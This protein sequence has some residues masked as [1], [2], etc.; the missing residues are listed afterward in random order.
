MTKSERPLNA[1]TVLIVGAGPTGLTLACELAR[2]DVSFRL[3]EAAPGPQPGSRGK[4][5]QP[6]TLEVF[7]NL[8]VI[9]RVLAHGRLAMPMH[10]ISP[11]GR[12]TVGGAVPESL[13]NRPDI[14]Y[15]TSLIT[16]EWRTEEALRLR[17]AEL[18]GAV[19]FGTSLVGFE[20]SDDGVSARVAVG[21]GG[22][23][24][25]VAV[26]DG[27]VAT[28]AA[29]W[30][31]GCDGGHSVVRKRAGIAFEGET[32][33]EVRMIVA[34]VRADGVD[35]DAWRVW[36]HAEGI[37]ALCPLPSTDA[38]QY[39]ASIAPGQDAQLTLA[40]LQAVLDRRTGGTGIRLHEPEWSSL[41]RANIRLA[42]RYREGRVFLAGDAAH[43]HSPAGGQGMNTG[44]QDAVNLGWKLA[45]VAQGAPSSLLD[46][47]ASER[48][49][50]AAH[51]LG[52]STARLEQMMRAKD[53]PT[54]RD[55]STIQ[56]DI[57]YRGLAL[58]HDDRD[59]N[60]V[61]RAGDR[62][63]D[64]TELAT[65]GGERR[66]YDLMHGG[67]FTLLCFG[68]AAEVGFPR[69]GVRVLRVVDEVVDGDD[70]ADTAGHLRRA[71]GAGERTLVLIRPDGYVGV[72]SDAGDASVVAGYLG[73]VCGAGV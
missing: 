8:G 69:V 24:A 11:D 29:R 1:P 71:Y 59:D 20:Q 30:L 7:E 70:V 23:S 68:G 56:L 48:R 35:R 58:A 14:P 72:V 16:P 36:R 12:V 34:D 4:G 28:V 57:G 2:R 21:K 25:R 49:P 46:T 60:A 62:A 63:P 45:A 73:A 54:R 13:A 52:F 51:V 22:V 3:I 31:V 19:E 67:R 55:A 40:N 33:E 47:Y 66:L 9:D 17:L 44:I 37:V 43:I 27:E 15:A 41:W 50:V 38:F 65:T 6:R 64:A 39:Q 26:G 61:L 32:R 18:G 53:I 10:S 42:D 5:V